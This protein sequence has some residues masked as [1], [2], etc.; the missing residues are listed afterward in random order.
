MAKDSGSQPTLLGPY[1]IRGEIGRGGMAI[2]Y[3]GTQPSLNRTVAIKVLPEQFAARPELLA[4]FER[5][6]SIIAQLSHPNLVQVIDRGR[7]GNTL[8]IV[9]EYVDG[10]GLD[11]RLAA[12][13][14]P[15]RDALDWAIQICDALDYAHGVGVVHRDLKPSNILIEMRTRRPK[16]TDFCIAQLETNTAG[17][18]TLTLDNSSIGTLNY[19]SPEQ[20]LDAHRVDHRTDIFS[21]G[22]ILYQ[23]ITGKLPL[24]HF[25]LPSFLRPDVPM[26]LD[27]VVTKCL[28]ESPDER[29][30]SA[31]EIREDLIRLTGRDTSA[32]SA[33]VGAPAGQRLPSRWRVVA[34]AAG[35]VLLATLG[36]LL[37]IPHWR[38]TREAKGESAPL[39]AVPH[40]P[41]AAT[42]PPPV[43][44]VPAA[45][46]A[47][48]PATTPVQ[49][50]APVEVPPVQPNV[51]AAPPQPAPEALPV[52]APQPP[53][54][55]VAPAAAA[56]PEA[57]LEAAFA[58]AQGLIGK[59]DYREAADALSALIRQDPGTAL[60][61]EAHFALA[62]VCHASG[63]RG[64][65]VTEYETVIRSFAT[66]PRVPQ[67]WL[68][69][70]RTE[71]ELASANDAKVVPLLGQ[72]VNTFRR[73]QATRIYNG[74]LQRRL[75]D[76][77]QDL[78]AKY[79]ESAHDLAARRLIVEIC[80]PPEMRDERL[81]AVN[82]V[83]ICDL[84]PDAGPEPLYEAARI[85]DR[86]LH[87]PQN[88]VPLYE[89]LQEQAPDNPHAETVRARL[90]ALRAK[91]H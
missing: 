78:V 19:M 35:I 15:W 45:T 50:N 1:E 27:H 55:A 18:A 69:K 66:S 36:A 9:M 44:T 29:Y 24:G 60:A 42:T 25:K 14:L 8:Y 91:S 77:L 28:A 63:E 49:A 54:A 61:A 12:G 48:T 71:W 47:A 58:H 84:D 10:G 13:A 34:G 80:V 46:P 82:L 33:P 51:P 62:G 6:G 26:G 73:G 52:L 72:I 11:T 21:F 20:R 22:V 17:L 79:P 37:L 68:G 4:R 53:T 90:T 7:Q 56:T 5:E 85:Y 16:I 74:E 89:R 87:E 39:P 3:L 32:T 30:Q 86:E 67:A 31:G 23:M 59:G 57:G 41:A 43:A 65:A 2:V 70:C 38:Q 81:A 75:V 40:T 83:R 76:E 88:A 64:R